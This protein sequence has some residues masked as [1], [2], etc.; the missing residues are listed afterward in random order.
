MGKKLTVEIKQRLLKKT[1][2]THLLQL[3]YV[4]FQIQNV[5]KCIS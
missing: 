1:Q 5:L 4:C 3:K 2:K